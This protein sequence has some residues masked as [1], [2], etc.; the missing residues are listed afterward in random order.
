MMLLICGQSHEASPLEGIETFQQISWD[1][2]LIQA[3][4]NQLLSDAQSEASWA[5]LLAA[6]W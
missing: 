3:A 5:H 6:A 4:Y 2:P 1:A